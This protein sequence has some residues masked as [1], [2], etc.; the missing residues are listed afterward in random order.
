MPLM[1]P[2]IALMGVGPNARWKDDD[3][4]SLLRR[5]LAP[6]IA[7][8][9]AFAA[10]ALLGNR[11]FRAGLHRHGV[12]CVAGVGWLTAIANGCGT[13][14]GWRA[15]PTNG[16]RYR[17]RSTACSSRILAWWPSSSASPP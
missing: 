15:L 5:M 14:P 12:R 17:S 6:A 1:L 10:C 3:G 13:L 8:A 16:S 4:K 7:A 9:L 2:L 11:F